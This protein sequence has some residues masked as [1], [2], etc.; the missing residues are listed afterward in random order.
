MRLQ[1][2]SIYEILLKLNFFF[3]VKIL[4]F[5]HNSVDYLVHK[6]ACTSPSLVTTSLI[7]KIHMLPWYMQL[8]STF[9]QSSYPAISHCLHPH[10]RKAISGSYCI[11]GSYHIASMCGKHFHRFVL[12]IFLFLFLEWFSTL[13]CLESSYL[14]DNLKYPAYLFFSFP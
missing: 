8:F 3:Y 11:L 1:C 14:K 5:F 13:I 6:L 12:C 2:W 4:T 10:T 9:S 7:D